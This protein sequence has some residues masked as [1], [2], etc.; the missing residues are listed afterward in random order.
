[1]KL[2]NVLKIAAI[3]IIAGMLCGCPPGY[4]SG[5]KADRWDRFYALKDE[6][7][8]VADSD[9]DRVTTLK[10]KVQMWADMGLHV[11]EVYDYHGGSYFKPMGEATESMYIEYIESKGYE[12]RLNKDTNLYEVRKEGSSWSFD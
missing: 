7:I 11:E 8:K 1:M 6:A 10:E 4:S 12:V 9:G 2:K 5:G 3:P